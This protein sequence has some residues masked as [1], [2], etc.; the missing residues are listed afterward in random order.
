MSTPKKRLGGNRTLAQWMGFAIATV[1]ARLLARPILQE[2]ATFT[3]YE[4][5]KKPASVT[6]AANSSRLI[7][8]PVWVTGAN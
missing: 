6:V 8:A 7:G 4:V 1:D 3:V 2:Y 5:A